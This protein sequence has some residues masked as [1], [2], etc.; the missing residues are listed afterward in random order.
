MPTIRPTRVYAN[1]SNYST[2]HQ[3]YFSVDTD[4]AHTV[5]ENQAIDAIGFHPPFNN[6]TTTWTASANLPGN[7]TI[8]AS[9]GE[10]TGTVNG[11]FAN[12]TI[13]VTATHNGSA[14]ETF[15]FNLQ[16]LADYDGDG[17][18]KRSAKQITMQPT[19]QRQVLL[20]TMMT[21]LTV[22]SIQSKLILEP[23]LMQQIRV[24]TH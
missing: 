17:L 9:T 3:L 7:L 19:N 14:T 11:T 4:N 15:T 5:V 18:A 10:I 8:D 23:T 22:C 16:S 2:T 1:Q 6:G 21:T 13:T 12:A 24:L 20:L